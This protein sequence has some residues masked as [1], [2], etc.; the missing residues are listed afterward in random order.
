MSLSEIVVPFL[1]KVL[2]L[3]SFYPEIGGPF[4][5]IKELHIKLSQKGINI[6]VLSPIPKNYDK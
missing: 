4:T 6:K 1:M 3:V 5:S 2:H